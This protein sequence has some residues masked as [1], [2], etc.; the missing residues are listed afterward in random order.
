[1][2]PNL[3]V[4]IIEEE[5]YFFKL[6]NYQERLL[7]LYAERQGFVLPEPQFVEIK[8]FV[9]QGLQDFSISRLKE[10]MSWGVPVPGDDKH[11][12]YVWFDALVNYISTIGWPHDME[13]FEKWWPV[14]QLAGKDQVRQQVV[15]WQAMLFSAG[16]P[17]SRQ[18]VIHGFVISGGQKMSKSLGN[19]V[20]PIEIVE[21]YGTDPLRYFLARHMHPFEDSDFTAEKF[22]EAYN[23]NLANG[24]GNL[25]ARIMK[26]V[27]EHLPVPVEHPAPEDFPEEYV[28]AIETFELNH[29]MDF[30]W[31]NVQKLDERITKEEPFKLI[32]SNPEAGKVLIAELVMEIY[33]VGRML[34]PFMPETSKK[35]KEAI[36]AN[37]KPETLFP[38]KD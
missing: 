27:E 19:V 1:M 12:M 33:Q 11:V 10:K 4:E 30:I 29:A 23:A 26:M 3:E 32:K 18:V 28:K 34:N 16:L 37:K 31:N 7:A 2:H 15:M 21:K 5:N 8:K 25:V 14:I 38:R 13:Q 36:L 35:I 17:P 20:N 24:L 6:S 9:A 22:K